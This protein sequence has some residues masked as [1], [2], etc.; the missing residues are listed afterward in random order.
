[1][2]IGEGVLSPY[3]ISMFSGAQNMEL[4]KAFIEFVVSDKRFC[5]LMLIYMA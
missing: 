4:T 2:L 3:L 5:I 1:M